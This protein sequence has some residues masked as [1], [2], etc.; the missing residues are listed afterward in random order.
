M[1][2]TGT[3]RELQVVYENYRYYKGITGSIWEY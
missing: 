3:I 2:I 1:R